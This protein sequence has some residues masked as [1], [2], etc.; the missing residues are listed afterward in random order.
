MSGALLLQALSMAALAVVILAGIES[1]WE[2]WW[3]VRNRL[4]RKR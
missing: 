1:A 3:R 2:I 4:A